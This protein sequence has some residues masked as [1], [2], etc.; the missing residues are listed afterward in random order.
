MWFLLILIVCHLNQRF[1]FVNILLIFSCACVVSYPMTFEGEITCA[2]F[3]FKLK[4]MYNGV[5][6]LIQVRIE[7]FV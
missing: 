7:F 2:I 6:W 4:F 3:V 5:F 1:W